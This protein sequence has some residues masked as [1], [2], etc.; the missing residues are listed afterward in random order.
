MD[1]GGVPRRVGSERPRSKRSRASTRSACPGPLPCSAAPTAASK[2]NNRD[3]VHGELLRC[4]G[5]EFAERD[6]S[7][8][9]LVMAANEPFSG[10]ARDIG[11]AEVS[12][13]AGPTR[14][15]MRSERGVAFSS[16]RGKLSYGTFPRGDSQERIHRIR[17]KHGSLPCARCD[18]SP[19]PCRAKRNRERKAPLPCP[20]HTDR[21]GPGLRPRP[22]S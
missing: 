22:A 2:E 12:P 9:E 6:C 3:R 16:G 11:S 8:G 14:V 19:N 1:R 7:G 17:G 13:P 21:P 18:S 20:V 10:S 5:W 15:R 4:L